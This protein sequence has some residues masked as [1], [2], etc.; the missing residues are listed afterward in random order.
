MFED[1]G[2]ANSQPALGHFCTDGLMYNQPSNDRFTE[3]QVLVIKR[4]S[5]AKKSWQHCP[6]WGYLHVFGLGQVSHSEIISLRNR[7][8][9]E[10]KLG[11][12]AWV[13]KILQHQHSS[14][15]W[16]KSVCSE[17]T[18][19]SGWSEKYLEITPITVALQ[20]LEVHQPAG[21]RWVG[22]WGQETTVPVIRSPCRRHK[23]AVQ[24]LQVVN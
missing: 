8:L 15:C 16:H 20:C 7:Q 22:W 14:R 9:S 23:D 6:T 3:H 18:D 12:Y 11:L 21:W 2:L 4:T 1:M 24:N 5:A 19:W 10:K 13:R 17:E